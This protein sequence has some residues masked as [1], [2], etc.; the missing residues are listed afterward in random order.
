MFYDRA[1]SLS[2]RELKIEMAKI[3][4]TRQE[5]EQRE[6]SVRRIGLTVAQVAMFLAAFSRR[7]TGSDD[8]KVE[9]AWL[10]K[11]AKVLLAEIRATPQE[12]SAVFRHVESLPELDNLLRTD[13]RKAKE[14]WKA[15]WDEVKKETHQE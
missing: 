10:S 9:I 8:Q 2:L 1:S 15:M 7:A 4:E 13:E 12:T 11:K 5:I 6:Q 3:E 14:K